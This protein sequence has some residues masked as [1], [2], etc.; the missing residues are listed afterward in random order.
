[1]ISFIAKILARAGKPG[2]ADLLMLLERAIFERGRWHRITGREAASILREAADDIHR[3]W[4][5]IAA[6]WEREGTSPA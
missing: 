3:R 4:H 6:R 2:P 5:A 1:M